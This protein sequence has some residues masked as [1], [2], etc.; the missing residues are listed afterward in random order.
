MERYCGCLQAGL[1]CHAHPW[2]SLN[3]RILHKAY[4]EQIDAFFGLEDQLTI[5]SKTVQAKETNYAS[6]KFVE[7]YVATSS[8]LEY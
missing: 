4:L 2:T 5:T 8:E 6:C 7:S 3:N 1:R